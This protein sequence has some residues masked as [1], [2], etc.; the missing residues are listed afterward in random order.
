M[1]AINID[2]TTIYFLVDYHP[3]RILGERNPNFDTASGKILDI[4]YDRDPGYNFFEP[5]VVDFV[6]SIIRKRDI[7]GIAMIPSH[8]KGKYSNSICRLIEAAS[9]ELGIEDF[10]LALKRTETIIKSTMGGERSIANHIRTIK[11]ALELIRGKNILLMDDVV[12]TGS[13][14]LASKFI[15]MKSKASSVTCISLARDFMEY[16]LNHEVIDQ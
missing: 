4:K 8:E 9:I 11:P 6:R 12:T 15:L 10:H 14:M 5:L 16:G 7:D 1:K 13:S 2:G 3:Y